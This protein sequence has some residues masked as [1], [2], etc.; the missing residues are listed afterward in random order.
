MKKKQLIIAAAALGGTVIAYCGASQYAGVQVQKTLDKQHKLIADLPYFVVKSR[1]YQMHMFSSTE[2]TTI[3]LAPNLLKPYEMLHLEEASKLKL[4][5]TYTQQIKHGPFPLL[6]SGNLTPLKAVVT[7]DIEFSPET[8]TLL[9]KVFGE[10]KALQIENRIHFNDDGVFTVK[11]PGFTYEETLAKV[12][13][14]WQG[15]DAGI[16]YTS[17]FDKIDITASAPGLHFEAGPKGT[18]DI[19][20]FRFES[21]NTR[22]KAGIM[23]GD[24]KLSLASAAFK[25]NEGDK[26]LDVKLDGV[27]YAVKTS[28]EGDFINS[29]GDVGVNAL[30]LNGK[31][32]GPAKLAVAANHLHGP[33]LA[34][35]SKAVS[36]IQREVADPTEQASKMLTVFR[37]E[38]LPLLR[39]DP[40]LAIKQFS[41]KL[42]EGEVS[43]KADLALKGFQDKDLD[44]PI[45][46]LEKLQASADIKVPKQVIETYVLWQARGMIAVDTEEGVRPDAEE[47]DNLAR[48]LME[49]QIRKLTEQNLIRADGDVLSSS[50]QWKAGRLNVNGKAIPLPWQMPLPASEA[51]AQ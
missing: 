34:A 15:F 3:A 10:Q 36:K 2:R 40:S 11:I 17:D 13:S 29:S 27:N 5:L 35:L 46:L 42:P 19:K 18:L 31:V 7:T 33:T 43:L 23:L 20:D 12:K 14:V 45:K 9:K 24:G 47:L 16:A 48:N 1:Q 50:A 8:Q 22:G 4:E 38:G 26:P 30:T 49:S 39:N 41:V 44:N 51:P 28:A 21:H 25:Q 32:Y 37:K 6:T